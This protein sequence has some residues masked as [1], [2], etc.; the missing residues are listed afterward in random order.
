MSEIHTDFPVIAGRLQNLL[1]RFLGQFELV[2]SL[3]QMGYSDRQLKVMG[4]TD[5]VMLCT[6]IVRAFRQSA[7]AAERATEWH[8]VERWLGLHGDPPTTLAT[9]GADYN[10]RPAHVAYRIEQT[11]RIMRRPL[12]RVALAATITKQIHVVLGYPEEWT[13][14]DTFFA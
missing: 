2:G 14:A 6:E 8:M 9:I 12:T 3:R 4:E 1:N 10:L 7:E 11:L 13:G 5:M